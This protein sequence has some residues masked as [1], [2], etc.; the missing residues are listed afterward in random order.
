MKKYQLRTMIRNWL[1]KGQETSELNTINIS[2]LG[3]HNANSINVSSGLTS[4]STSEITKLVHNTSDTP[5]FDKE[6]SIKFSVYKANGGM[7]VET[8]KYNSNTLKSNTNL[9]II[10]NTAR[11]G[12]ELEK[13]MTM[14][15]LR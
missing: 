1:N 13:I 7:I 11:F 10:N 5:S 14:E 3:Y 12:R 6:K 2:G 4:L 8:T 15:G 9:Y